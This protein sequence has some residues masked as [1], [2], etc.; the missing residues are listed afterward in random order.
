LL[1]EAF[2]HAEAV[3]APWV[4]RMLLMLPHWR[5]LDPV[6]LCEVQGLPRTASW[7]QAVAARPSVQST[8]AGEEEMVRASRRYYVNY[9]S[10]GTPGEKTLSAASK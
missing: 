5:G 7:M 9:A 1:G 6:R 2:S 10:P 8:S 3:A 4:E